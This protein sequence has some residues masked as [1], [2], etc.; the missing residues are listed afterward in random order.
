[1]RY[2]IELKYGVMISLLSLLWLSLE[3]MVGFHDI[4]IAHH[5][6]VSLLSLIIPVLV[7]RHALQER[8]IESGQLTFRQAFTSA[9]IITFITTMLAAP[10]QLVFHKI[11]NP[12]FF[13]NMIEYAVTQRKLS[14]NEAAR[15]FNFGN[16]A[17]QSVTGSLVVGTV[18]SMLLAYFAS[19]KPQKQ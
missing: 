3:F 19:K 6:Y 8:K 4:H 5:P 15:Y 13:M 16:Y 1:M 11:V 9:M 12:D 10:V 18:V 2:R 17:M 14:P 7:M